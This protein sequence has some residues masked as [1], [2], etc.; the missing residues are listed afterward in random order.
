MATQG[1]GSPTV[2]EAYESAASLAERAQDADQLFHS[3][4]NIWHV[5][6]VKGDCRAAKAIALDLIAQCD[7]G[8]GGSEKYY[9]LLV[10]EIRRWVESIVKY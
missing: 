5:N 9:E 3:K 10:A 8:L 2:S 4:F 1:V 7:A 6:N